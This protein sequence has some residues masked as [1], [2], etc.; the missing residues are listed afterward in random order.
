MPRP[1]GKPYRRRLR[2]GQHGIQNLVV[3]LDATGLTSLRH[4]LAEL[5]RGLQKTGMRRALTKATRPVA[6]AMR[7]MLREYSA[8]SKRR[9]GVGT[10]SRA[11]IVK[12][13]QAKSDPAR[14]YSI[15]GIRRNWNERVYLDNAHT[16][17][18]VRSVYRKKVQSKKN[19]GNLRYIQRKNLSATARN[20]RLSPNKLSRQRGH[21]LRHPA[22]YF[23]LID[24][25]DRFRKRIKRKGHFLIRSRQV[26]NPQIVINELG[27]FIRQTWK[28]G[29]VT[30]AA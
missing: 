2:G 11:V 6:K 17:S 16:R 30:R 20:A 19:R 25:G 22:K 26:Y 5:P 14:I 29:K 24:E 15:V 1:S 28:S 21:I 12:T 10:S 13:R 8:G 23:H 7:Q 27:A 18:G 9:E 4:T 3:R